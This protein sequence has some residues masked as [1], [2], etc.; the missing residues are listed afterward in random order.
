MHDIRTMN[1][2][3]QRVAIQPVV[4]PAQQLQIWNA[5]AQ[6]PQPP[7]EDVY[8]RRHNA[9]LTANIRSLY[10]L[11]QEYE[12][13]IGGKKAAKDFTRAERGKC[14]FTY[15]RRKIAWDKIRDL[16]CAGH[17]ADVAIDMIY[18]AY[19]VGTSVTSI[20]NS[21]REDRKKPRNRRAI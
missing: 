5:E 7:R 17:T 14:K 9:I 20:I 2:S 11:W 8:N 6:P 4:R 16:I 12:F 13:G 18:Q 1:R 10:V 21:I 19:G 3:I 15:G